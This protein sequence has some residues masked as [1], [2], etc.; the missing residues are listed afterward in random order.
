VVRLVEGPERLSVSH[1]NMG[2]RHSAR[3]SSG[4]SRQDPVWTGPVELA[5]TEFAHVAMGG[6]CATLNVYGLWAGLTRFSSALRQH[7]HY[8]ARHG[9]T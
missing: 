5:I 6:S 9:A 4:V 3:D 7:Q 2:I 8:H 1:V